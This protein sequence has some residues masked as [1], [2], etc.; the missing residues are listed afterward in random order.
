MERI[1]KNLKRIVR[2]NGK[3]WK[4]IE[5]KCK[6]KWKELKRIEKNC[7]ERIEKNWT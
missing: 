2:K 5:K 7:M 6:K 3:N 1:E 4:E